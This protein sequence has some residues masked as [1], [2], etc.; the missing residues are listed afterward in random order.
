[1]I[2]FINSKEVKPAELIHKIQEQ[3]GESYLEKKMIY[4]WI[5]FF[6]KARLSLINNEK[7]YFNE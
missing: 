4:K 2:Y 6:E 1:M 7:I 5:D 3:Y